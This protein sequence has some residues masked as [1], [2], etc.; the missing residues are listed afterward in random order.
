MKIAF[1]SDIHGV[2]ETLQKFFDHS[3]ALGAEL[4]VL[5]GDAL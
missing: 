1:F 4:L 2:P 3:D 5:L